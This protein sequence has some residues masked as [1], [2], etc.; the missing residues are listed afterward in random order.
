MK[1]SVNQGPSKMPIAFVTRFYGAALGGIGRYE[2]TLFRQL[3]RF[4]AVHHVAVA[5]LPLPGKIRSLSR[6]LGVDLP[7]VMQNNPCY[8]PRQKETSLIH[9]SNQ[10]IALA[11]L[12]HHKAKKVITV[13]DIIPFVEHPSIGLSAKGAPERCIYH[14]HL[15]SLFVADRIIADSEHTKSDLIHRLHLPASKIR[16]VPLGVDTS[17]FRPLTHLDDVFEKY[18]LDPRRAYILY[19]GS[20]HPRKNLITLLHAV[21]R[22]GKQHPE[23]QLLVVGASRATQSPELAEAIRQAQQLDLVRLLDLVSEQDLVRL[24]NL[25]TL[26]AMP[27]RYEGFGLPVLEAMAA[28]CPV[29]AS[30]ATSIPEVVGD[31]GTLLPPM[32]VDAWTVALISLLAHPQQRMEMRERGLNR[33]RQMTWVRTAVSTA[34]VYAELLRPMHHRMQQQQ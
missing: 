10:T 21:I 24:Y 18:N 33:A 28:G 30:N 22:A 12:S 13:H 27:S 6:L 25:V 9:L 20:Q 11:M 34:E 3:Q 29:V 15:K 16:V 19:V 2:E 8:I 1:P 5:P 26:S 23:L 14:M 31:A 4:I 17:V 32:D 7:A